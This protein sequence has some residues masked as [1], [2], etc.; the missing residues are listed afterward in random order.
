MNRVNKA[1]NYF[2]EVFSEMK[3]VDWP[4]RETVYKNTQVVVVIS[5][6]LA[7]ILAI[8]DSGLTEGLKILLG[9]TS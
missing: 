4:K 3:R 6:V 9:V 8:I 7:V 1:I 5:L 2:K